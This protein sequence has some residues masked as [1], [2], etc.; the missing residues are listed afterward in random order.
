[1]ATDKKLLAKGIQYLTGSLPVTF[2]G[3][4]LISFSFVNK[5]YTITGLG[6]VVTGFA[7]YLMFKGIKTI[8]RSL[9]DG[10]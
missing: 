3:I 7:M 9:F 4:Y 6:I 5:I 10:N 8:M 2:I 1:M